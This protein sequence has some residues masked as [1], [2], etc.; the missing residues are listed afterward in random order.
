[1]SKL[2]VHPAADI[3]PMMSEEELQD[4]AEDIKANGL[5]H[6]LIVDKDNQLID[7][8]NRLAACKLAGIEPR[9]EQLNGRD[10]L[11]YIASANL[12]RRNL[13]KG[14]QAMALA[15]IYPEKDK[16]GRG[17]KSEALNSAETSGFSTRRLNCAR[18]V[19]KFS[20]P[21]AE[22]VLKGT[23]SLDQVLQKVEAEQRRAEGEGARMDRLRK[24]APD[25]ADLV[26]D[27]RMS[28]NE[29]T[30]AWS[31]RE[32]ERRAAYQSGL[33]S[34]ERLNEFVGHVTAIIGGENVRSESD[35]PIVVKA[36][37]LKHLKAAVELLEKFCARSK[38]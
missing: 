8:R 3:F 4:L 14:Q 6:P 26:A 16:G 5:V 21:M 31:Q 18:S 29:A 24:G 9:F 13:T 22:A 25:L 27:E 37:A 36:E 2:T 17:K 15:M 11:A 10:P 7:G 1:M 32:Q 19:L 12:K 28:L 35:P 33:S 34:A 20:R 30:A 38:K 23:D